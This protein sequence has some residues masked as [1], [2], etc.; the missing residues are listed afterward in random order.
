MR[1][2]KKVREKLSLLAS[3][4]L[5]FIL[6]PLDRKVVVFK[7]VDVFDFDGSF[8]P[9]FREIVGNNPVILIAN[10]SDL[11]PRR[12]SYERVTTWLR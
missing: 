3:T 12:V 8:L 11:L 5:P 1:D 9:D 4:F 10:K 2:R 7:V 6:S